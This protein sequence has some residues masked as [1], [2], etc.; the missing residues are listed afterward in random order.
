MH[1]LLPFAKLRIVAAKMRRSIPDPILMRKT[2]SCEEDARKPRLRWHKAVTLLGCLVSPASGRYVV[3]VVMMTGSAEAML[4]QS[5]KGA[6]EA[7][8][9]R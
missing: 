3:T 4:L 8:S 5:A 7:R 6:Q 2:V 1:H 9:S